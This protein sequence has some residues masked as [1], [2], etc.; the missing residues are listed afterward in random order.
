MTSHE[1]DQEGNQCWYNA[2][3]DFHREDG[4][5]II[6]TDGRQYWYINGVL[7]RTDG[8]AIICDIIKLWYVDGILYKDNKSFQK[9]AKLTDEDMLMINLK[10]RDVSN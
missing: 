4:P 1:I 10:Y 9:A 7:H 6:C 3:D 8:P 2:D 5:A